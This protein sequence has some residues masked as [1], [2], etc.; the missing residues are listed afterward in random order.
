MPF[1]VRKFVFSS[2]D[3]RG[4]FW[5]L[6]RVDPDLSAND[7]LLRSNKCI[8][9]VKKEI[10]VYHTCARHGQFAE[11]AGQ[12]CNLKPFQLRALYRELTGR[13][14]WHVM[15]KLRINAVNSFISVSILL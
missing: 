15:L 3:N 12:K 9:D 6:W 13:V 11:K 8:L 4:D 1:P 5:L 7:E 14:A 2:G 10:P